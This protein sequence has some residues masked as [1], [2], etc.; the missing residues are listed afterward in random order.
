MPEFTKLQRRL[1][2]QGRRADRRRQRAAR[3]AGQGARVRARPL[4]A[5]P[6]LA[7]GVARPHGGVRRGPGAAGDRDRGRAGPAGGADPGRDRRGTPARRCSTSCCPS[8]PRP[9]PPR[10]AA[11]SSAALSSPRLA[12]H[13]L[14]F[15]SGAAA[16]PR[17]RCSDAAASR[18]SWEPRP[19]RSPRR[20][21]VLRGPRPGQLLL[22]RLAPAS[23][24][25][26]GRSRCSDRQPGISA[27]AVT[28]CSRR[29]SPPTPRLYGA[30][31]GSPALLLALKVGVADRRRVVPATCMGGTLPL[32]AQL[33]AAEAQQLGVRAGGLYA[34]KRWAPP[35]GPSRPGPLA[36]AGWRHRRACGRG[37]GEPADRPWRAAARASGRN[38]VA[39]PSGA[40]GSGPRR[41]P[42]RK[43]AAFA[44]VSGAITL[45]LEALA[46]RA[47]ALV[48][49]NSVYSSRRGVLRCFLAGALGRRR[50]AGARGAA[51]GDRRSRSRRGGVA[52]AGAWIALLR[53]PVRARHRPRVPRRRRP[54]RARGAARRAGGGGAAGRRASCSAWRL[55]A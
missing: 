35:L 9:R 46:T 17:T 7:R 8:R 1:P 20:S 19:P 42:A 43:H 45:G 32:L 38:R 39:G 48:H 37:G 4:D 12:L 22:G 36:P 6:D 51:A 31:S 29:R 40:R 14:F 30:S 49:E 52:G 25:R 15:S 50:L 18:C 11:R 5:V 41:P 34:V 47:F 54:A 24:G 3:G 21:R 13:A 28:R 16:L 26:C 27:L 2:G 23:P 44:L 10:A 33:V 55:P 53:G